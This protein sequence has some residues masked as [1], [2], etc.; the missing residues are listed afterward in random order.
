M[1]L[2]LQ[3][4]NKSTASQKKFA[5]DQKFRIGYWAHACQRAVEKVLSLT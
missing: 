3:Q 2:D 4:A 1:H 5:N